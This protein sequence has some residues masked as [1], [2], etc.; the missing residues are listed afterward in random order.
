LK[1]FE[2]IEEF[3]KNKNKPKIQKSKKVGNASFSSPSP[4]YR[5]ERKSAQGIHYNIKK[6]Q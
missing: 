5:K 6:R 1:K 4:F 3:E 2:K